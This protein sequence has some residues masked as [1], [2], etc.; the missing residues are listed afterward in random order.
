MQR[1][2]QKYELLLKVQGEEH[3]K[4]IEEIIQQL[5]D[6][7]VKYQVDISKLQETLADKTA[8]MNSLNSTLEDIRSSNLR[9]VEEFSQQQIKF[10]NLRQDY[11]SC[12]Q[13]CKDLERSME[14]AQNDLGMIRSQQERLISEAVRVA[15]EE[16]RAEADRQFAHANK[17]FLQLKQDYSDAVEERQMWIQRTEETTTN[18]NNAMQTFQS[19]IDALTYQLESTRTELELSKIEHGK[20]KQQAQSD[21]ALF[22]ERMDNMRREVA[23]M[24]KECAEAHQLVGTAVREKEK[25]KREV[26]ELK[27]VCEELMSMVEVEEQ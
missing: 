11:D 4:Q 1:Q 13:N 22:S 19:R 17:M 5:N 23:K 26:Q 6:I 21:S 9:L 25:L 8:A 10:A 3:A 2:K 27:G 24:E 20:I 16:I 18:A 12:V 7:E 14:N 15:Q